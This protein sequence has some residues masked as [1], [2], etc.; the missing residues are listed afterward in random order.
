MIK[1]ILLKI[2][3]IIIG[4]LVG[5]GVSNIQQTPEKPQFTIKHN[6]DTLNYNAKITYSEAVNRCIYANPI[7]T[8]KCF[9]KHSEYLCPKA[10]YF[11]A[12]NTEEYFACDAAPGFLNAEILK[13]CNDRNKAVFEYF[14]NARKF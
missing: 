14:K 2:T 6:C 10:V 11:K 5:F 4:F 9:E 8:D 3:F 13:G 12:P 1:Y 7:D